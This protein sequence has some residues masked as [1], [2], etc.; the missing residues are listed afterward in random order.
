MCDSS[1]AVS[2]IM[3]CHNGDEFLIEA[4]DSIY[5]QTFPDWEIVF[6][7]NAST[8][9]SAQMANSYDSRLNYYFSKEKTLLGKARNMA[10][11]K[12]T[13]KYIAFLDCDD[14]WQPDK[15]ELQIKL[16]Q[17]KPE[18]G[19][20]YS[21]CYKYF[22]PSEKLEDK[23]SGL[24]N[25][26]YRGRVL[27]EL[28]LENF[29]PM[30]TVMVKKDVLLEAGCFCEEFNV[31]TD[32]DLWLRVAR[33]YPIDFVDS[34]LANYRIHD[35]SVTQKESSLACREHL[36]VLDRCLKRDP[37][38]KKE[39]N[40]KINERISHKTLDLSSVYFKNFQI[41]SAMKMLFKSLFLYPQ[42][43][44]FLFKKI[45]SLLDRNVISILKP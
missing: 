28:F 29:I 38:L 43:L 15:L 20:V 10:I 24:T 45:K 23:F 36:R 7:D 39:L 44:L 11:Q 41:I 32:Y 40:E 31:G 12:A 33:N 27:N 8:D 21:N 17:N 14:S 16:F 30:L 22:W 2:I 13:G 26:P 6:W 37:W 18:L 1:P 34:T 42:S 19:M 4:I 3:N 25:G 35:Q 5:S 9:E